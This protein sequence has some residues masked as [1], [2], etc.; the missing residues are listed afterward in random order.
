M[1]LKGRLVTGV[2]LNTQSFK[3]HGLKGAHQIML[4]I[5]I[6]LYLGVLSSLEGSMT[7]IHNYRRMFK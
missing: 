5:I 1:H 4:T 6:C 2:R 3:H 7:S